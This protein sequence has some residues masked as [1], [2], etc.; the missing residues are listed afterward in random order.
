MPRLDGEWKS[1]S[2]EPIGERLL[3]FMSRFPGGKRVRDFGKKQTRDV[4]HLS[5][6]SGGEEVMCGSTLS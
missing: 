6:F 5:L 2:S 1:I 3:F 4:S